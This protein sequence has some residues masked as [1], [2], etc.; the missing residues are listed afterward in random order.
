VSVGAAEPGS[1]VEAEDSATGAASI[2]AK[3]AVRAAKRDLEAKGYRATIVENERAIRFVKYEGPSR[4][5]TVFVHVKSA[6]GAVRLLF[7]IQESENG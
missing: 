5:G 4:S 1:V 6:D 3:P 7:R 2:E